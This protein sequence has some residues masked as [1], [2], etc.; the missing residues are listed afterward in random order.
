MLAKQNRKQRFIK[1]HYY[2]D[3]AQRFSR[4]ESSFEYRMQNISYVFAEM[5]R[6][7][8]SGL[9]PAKNIGTATAEKIEKLINQAKGTV[10]Q[11]IAAY[12]ANI[13]S[14]A[15]AKTTQKPEGTTEP[16]KHYSTHEKFARDPRVKAWVLNNANG[17]C[18]CCDAATPF[19]L[20]PPSKTHYPS[21]RSGI[22]HSSC[23]ASAF[24]RLLH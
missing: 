7:Y 2:Q 4:T 1:K 17:V 13:R 5:G 6:T 8:I 16:D 14:V 23:Y 18:E 22:R 19:T 12:E 10:Y 9:L 20:S 3:L 21:Y 11:G 24:L 15:H